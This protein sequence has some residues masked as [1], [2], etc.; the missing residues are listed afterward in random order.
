MRRMDRQLCSELGLA[1]TGPP[2][3]LSS[4]GWTSPPL[5]LG[6]HLPLGGR[7]QPW[8]QRGLLCAGFPSQL[9]VEVLSPAEGRGQAPGGRRMLAQT[10]GLGSSAV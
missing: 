10:P 4:S 8:L 6:T 9:L 1:V 7:W 2:C 5:L 3:Q